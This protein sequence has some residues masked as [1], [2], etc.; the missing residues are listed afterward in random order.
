VDRLQP[1]ALALEIADALQ[2][3]MEQF[4]AIANELRE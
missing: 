4:A 2:T 3:A 1:D